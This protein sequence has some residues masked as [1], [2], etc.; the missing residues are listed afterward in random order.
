MKF[1]CEMTKDDFWP[2]C[3]LKGDRIDVRWYDRSAVNIPG[4]VNPRT[5][6]YS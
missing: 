3:F 2:V 1:I 5:I 6:K 4:T